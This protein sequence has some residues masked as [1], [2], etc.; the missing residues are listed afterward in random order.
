MEV[1]NVTLASSSQAVTTPQVVEQT[2]SDTTITEAFSFSYEDYLEFLLLF[3][4]IIS[5]ESEENK[6]A[7]EQAQQSDSLYSLYENSKLPSLALAQMLDM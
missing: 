4:K 3:E 6:N 7:K 2:S 1:P 5:S